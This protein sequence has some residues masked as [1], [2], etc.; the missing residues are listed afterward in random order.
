MKNNR[1]GLINRYF[2]LVPT[3]ASAPSHASWLPRWPVAAEL[4]GDDN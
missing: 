1:F 4:K 2:S 3:R